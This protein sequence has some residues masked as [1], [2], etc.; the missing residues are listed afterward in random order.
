M[1]RKLEIQASYMIGVV[2]GMLLLLQTGCQE[3][4]KMTEQTS[5]AEIKFEES[6]YDFGEV[7][8]S[9]K[10]KGQF[11]FTNVGQGTLK[12]TKVSRCCGVVTRLDKMEY[13]PGESGVLN[14][15][16]NSG[17][18]EST[19]RRQIIVH[20]ND[21]TNPQTTL[22]ITAKTVS[23]VAWEPK[24][25]KL[26]FDEENAG[27]PKIKINSIDN[28]PFSITGFKSTADC[29]TFDYDPDVEATEFVL[30]PKVKLDNLH[31]RNKGRIDISLNHPQGNAAT[32]LYS[33][34]PKYTVNSD[35]LILFDA[36][37]E[38]P[39]VR[40]ISVLNNYQKDFEIESLTSENEVVTIKLQKQRKIRNGYQL[41]VEIIP[42]A[43]EG[44]TRFTDLFSINLK[45][46]E[47]LPVRCNGYYKKIKAKA[48]AQQSASDKPS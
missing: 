28:R 37:P 42:P 41:E 24:Q 25:L 23:K 12:I 1:K 27:C 40:T 44:K 18:L 4:A 31:K 38:E 3:Q 20:S 8:P 11:K 26:F 22:T 14:V 10:H 7:G 39:I 15:E 29:I 45:D 5:P 16:W 47:K 21:T 36:V 6:V 30:E 35:L 43:S 46:G 48:A 2:C 32:I 17:P 9:A 33:V 34:V 19:L 13:A